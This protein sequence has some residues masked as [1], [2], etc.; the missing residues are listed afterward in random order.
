MFFISYHYISIVFFRNC[1]FKTE[2]NCC[3]RTAVR[4]QLMTFKLMTIQILKLTVPTKFL[5]A[6]RTK[7]Y[8]QYEDGR[9]SSRNTIHSPYIN[10]GPCTGRWCLIYWPAAPRRHCTSQRNTLLRVITS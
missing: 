10:I 3:Y 8:I 2:E 4:F 6:K 1:S 7:K 9:S 5:S